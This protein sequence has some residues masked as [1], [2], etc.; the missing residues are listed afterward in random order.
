ME[1]E[2]HAFHKDLNKGRSSGKLTVTDYG[3][4]FSCA[5]KQAHIPIDNIQFSLGGASHRLVFIAHPDHSDWSIYTNDLTILNNPL[6]KN[7]ENIKRQLNKL[8]GHR[9][10]NWSVL[11]ATLLLIVALPLS[12]F[13]YIDAVTAI[14]AKNIPIEWEEQL[15]E[16]TFAQYQFDHEIIETDEEVEQLS[17]LTSVLTQQVEGDRY[18]FNIYIANDPSI[19]AFAL[20][21]GYVVIHTGL[22][23]KADSAEEMLGVLGHEISHVTKQHGIRNII[24]TASVYLMAQALIGDVSGILAIIAGAAPL[25]LSQQYSRNFESEADKEGYALL[26][27]ANID[28]RGL[29]DFFKKII[30]EE[31]KAKRKLAETSEEAVKL[32]EVTLDFFSS[33]PATD[34]RIEEIELMIGEGIHSYANFDDEFLRLQNMVKVFV[35]E[36]EQPLDEESSE[37]DVNDE[38][39]E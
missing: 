23:L 36:Q 20:P 4:S 15:G 22:I 38:A 27:K 5:E 16:K 29:V 3:I 32:L 26:T 17:K 11:I 30:E 34:E 10:L 2:A 9:I 7:D 13:L 33:H 31:E 6:L 35:A 25:L 14:V 28:P 1:Y 39:T 8:K 21:G 37:T 24:A 18:D 12:F 19:N